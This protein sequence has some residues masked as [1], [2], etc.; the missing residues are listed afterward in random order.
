MNFISFAFLVLLVPVIVGR[1]TIGREKTEAPF[2][3]LVL[4][5]STVFVMWHVP[6]YIAIVL[7][8][9]GTDY[10]AAALMDREPD[11]SRRRK[12][13]LAGSLGTNLLLL[14]AFKYTNF[15]SES[16]EGAAHFMGF[17]WSLPRVHW[18]LPM[19][20]S[21]YTF[22]SMSYTIDVYRRRIRPV[23]RFRDLYYFVSFFPTW[24]PA[25]SSGRRTF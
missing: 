15:L 1:L 23:S 8:S 21:F 6:A 7:L 20:I 24:W 5:A 25:P 2:R 22:G 13:L 10:V 18:A 3:W 19:G 14:G 16:L 11:G 4:A 17:A 9:T 12:W